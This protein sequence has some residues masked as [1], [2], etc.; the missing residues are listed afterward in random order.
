MLEHE[1]KEGPEKTLYLFQFHDPYYADYYLKKYNET[2]PILAYNLDELTDIAKLRSFLSARKEPFLSLAWLSR[3]LP[4]HVIPVI[5]EYYPFLKQRDT[6]FISEQYIFSKNPQPGPQLLFRAK[7]DFESQEDSWTAEDKFE[8]DSVVWKGK[9]SG[10]ITENQQYGPT[11]HLNLD[12]LDFRPY[13]EL[14]ITAMVKLKSLDKDLQLVLQ[15]SREKG[16][17]IW[18]SE[19]VRRFT[20]NEND[21]NAV[22]YFVR[23]QHLELGPGPHQLKAYLWNPDHAEA[24]FDDLEFRIEHGNPDLYALVEPICD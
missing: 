13:N 9:F 5:R 22:H 8:Q 3:P 24:W 10:Y 23:L 1:K 14:W 4:P 11:L 18:R 2:L 12:T 21:W 17:D 16:E 7:T 15:I 20:T 19:S 6:Y